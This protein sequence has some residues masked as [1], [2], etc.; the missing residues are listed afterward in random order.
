MWLMARQ[1][2]SC[3]KKEMETPHTV[4][5]Y[6]V[7][8]LVELVGRWHIPADELLSGAGLTTESLEDPLARLP[9]ATMG[10]LLERARQLTGEAGLGYYSGLHKRATGYGTLGFAA[11]SAPS[12]LEAL[13]VAVK[14]AP[15][16]STAVSLDL[17]VDGDPAS[18]CLEENAD[19]GPSRDIVI[20]SMMLGLQTMFSALTGR[21][22]DGSADLAIPEPAYQARFTHIVPRW[23]FGQPANRLLLD[24]ATLGSPIVTAD[25]TGL[26][27]ARTLCER[28]LDEL[29]YDAG[30]IDR[31]RRLLRRD[32]GGFRS[33]DEVAACM[34]VSERTLKRQLAARGMSFSTLAERERRERAMVLLRSHRLSISD[35]ADRLDYSTASTFVRAFHRWTG[36]TPAAYRRGSSPSAVDAGD[37][38]DAAGATSLA[39]SRSNAPTTS[40]T[41]T[42]FFKKAV[43][44]RAPLYAIPRSSRR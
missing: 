17:R 44:I 2:A 7:S 18:L 22:Q 21:P 31:V 32:D 15:V 40:A 4:P 19:L 26:R 41:S 33:L 42:P 28:A 1:P 37:V 16:F 20:I 8:Q 12:V 13:K 35:V 5:F 3:D 24:A 23:R 9:V 10:H 36:T 27:V 11:S 34:H 6:L 30:L 29:G 25:S 14:F 39:T 38:S 43:P